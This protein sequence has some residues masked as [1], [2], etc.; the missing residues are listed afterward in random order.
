[1][2]GI[3]CQDLIYLIG[4]KDYKAKEDLEKELYEKLSYRPLKK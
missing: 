1:V 2:F 4:T 3:T